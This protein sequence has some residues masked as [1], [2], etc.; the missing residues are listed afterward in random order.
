MTQFRFLGLDKVCEILPVKRGDAR[1]YFA[2]VYSA[3][4]MDAA[5]LPSVF[6][7]DN[8]SLSPKPGTLRGMHF[9][10][11]PFAQDKLVRVTRGAILDVVADVRRGSPSFGRHVSLILSEE[12]FNQL[13]VPKGFAHGFVTLTADTEVLYKVSAP[14]APNHERSVRFDDPDLNISWPSDHAPFVISDKDAAAPFLADCDTGFVY[15]A[16]PSVRR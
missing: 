9:Q 1:G 16:A 11:P 2:E 8:H 6:V 13:F 7:Q 12:A 5:G 14:Y 3:R 4:D 15:D 10:T